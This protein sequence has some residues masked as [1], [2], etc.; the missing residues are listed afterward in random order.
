[1]NSEHVEEIGAD[2]LLLD[3][4]DTTCSEEIHAACAAVD[5]AVEKR[6][7]IA[8]E[9]PVSAGLAG[10][11][12]GCAV[13]PVHVCDH[14]E[15]VRVGVGQGT[16]EDR[17][18]DAINGRVCADAEPERGKDCDREGGTFGELAG[19][20]SKIVQ[21]RH[22]CTSYMD[23]IRA[24]DSKTGRTTTRRVRFRWYFRRRFRRRVEDFP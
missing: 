10:L 1:M 5:C 23:M 13:M 7:M 6:G 14:H 11:R 19:G 8:D 12:S 16:K 21:E 9:L 3:V 20:E 17:I 4:F 15:A 24:V 22:A 18:H 2:S